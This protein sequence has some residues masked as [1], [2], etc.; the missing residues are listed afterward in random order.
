[1]HMSH[2][3]SLHGKAY[4]NLPLVYAAANKADLV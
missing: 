4:A 1:M 2:L 3:L